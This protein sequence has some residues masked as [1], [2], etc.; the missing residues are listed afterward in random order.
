MLSY[1]RWAIITLV[2]AYLLGMS[3][4][5]RC[6]MCYDFEA[7]FRCHNG[8]DTSF[9]AAETY[10]QL[11]DSLSS[12]HPRGYNC[13]TLRFVHWPY[14]HGHNSEPSPYCSSKKRLKEFV[15]Q[16]DICTD[17][18]KNKGWPF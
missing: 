8:L 12:Y 2:L 15:S 16:F 4:C 7:Q 10:V 3:A 6:V 5:D 17:E 1:G 9:F 13:D 14:D 11:N 18:G